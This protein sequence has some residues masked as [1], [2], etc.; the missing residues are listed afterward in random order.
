MAPT[1]LRL[2]LQDATISATL[3]LVC[4]TKMAAGVVAP[5]QPASPAT[6]NARKSALETLDKN[7]EVH[8]G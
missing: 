6:P 2:A 5:I 7:V 8:L 1:A 3:S 4:K